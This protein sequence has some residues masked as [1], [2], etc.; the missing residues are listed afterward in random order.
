MELGKTSKIEAKSTENRDFFGEKWRSK[1]NIFCFRRKKSCLGA[2]LDLLKGVGARFWGRFELFWV[3][4]GVDFDG[5]SNEITLGCSFEGAIWALKRRFWVV[6]LS[7][8]YVLWGWSRIDWGSF[9]CD[10]VV[11]G[12]VWRWLRDS[13]CRMVEFRGERSSPP[14]WLLSGRPVLYI[15]K[16]WSRPQKNNLKKF[17]I[18]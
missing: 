2:V 5:R 12:V 18:A 13:V 17:R 1:N 9:G 6:I 10:L 4:L 3:I 7:F 16:S 8:W 11:I 14:G 15:E